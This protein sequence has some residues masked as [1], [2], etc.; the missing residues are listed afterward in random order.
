MDEFP[1]A[2]PHRPHAGFGAAAIDAV[3]R[4]A[5]ALFLPGEHGL[6]TGTFVSLRGGDIREVAECGE[7]VEQVDVSLHAAAGFDAG[8]LHDERHAPRVLVEILLPLQAVTADC[9]AVVGRIENDGVFELAHGLEFCEHA[10]D[11]DVDVLA[12]CE[13]AAEFVADG[14]LVAPLPHAADGHFVAQAGVAV[15]EGM[16][17][18]IVRRQFRLLGIGGRRRTLVSVI[19]RAVFR[20]QFRRAVAD[21]V[22]M[23]EAVVDEEGLGVLPRLALREII[24]HPVAMPRAAGFGGAAALGGVVADGKEFVR[25]LVALALFAGPHR[26]VAGPVEERGDRLLHDVQRAEFLLFCLWRNGQVPHAAAG[27][28][29]VTRRRAD[30]TAER[31]HV[32]SAIED[33]ALTCE[34]VNVRGLQW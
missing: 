19:D 24:H 23:R 2:L 10:A 6:E 20:Q 29:H 11:L 17:G 33:H 31:A 13:L 28:D 16:R 12:A 21:V 15:I 5:D 32:I 4:V 30:R 1:I 3:E 25:G 26:G 22:R 14:P 27:H 9:H 34:A 8:A 7:H 18:E